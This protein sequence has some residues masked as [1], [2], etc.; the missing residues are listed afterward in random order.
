[1]ECEIYDRLEKELIRI[2]ERG[3]Q[4]SMDREL[5]DKEVQQLVEEESDAIMRL[6]DHRSEHGCKRPGE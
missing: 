6:T 5:T 3:T 1:V 4:L 2:R